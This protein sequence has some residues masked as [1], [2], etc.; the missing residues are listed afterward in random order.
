VLTV[1]LIPCNIFFLEPRSFQMGKAKRNAN[2]DHRVRPTGLLSEQET[3]QIQE[4]EENVESEYPIL[5]QVRVYIFFSC[6]D[7]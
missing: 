2:K 6:C 5:D 4:I 3:E 1:P 7:H